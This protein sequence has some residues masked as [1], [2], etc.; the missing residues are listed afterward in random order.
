MT[1]KTTGCRR[2]GWRPS[3]RRGRSPPRTQAA[4]APVQQEHRV[5]FELHEGAGVRTWAASVFEQRRAASPVG[6]V[7][8]NS[9]HAGPAR[10]FQNR[11]GTINDWR[12]EIA[13]NRVRIRQLERAYARFL[14]VIASLRVWIVV[15]A[16]SAKGQRPRLRCARVQVAVV[17]ACELAENQRAML[18]Q[19]ARK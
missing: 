6:D 3:R 19:S 9:A 5:S 11:L 10:T 4:P 12:R 7:V 14:L 8:I 15:L 16:R 1:E 18:A 2:S 17:V 13:C